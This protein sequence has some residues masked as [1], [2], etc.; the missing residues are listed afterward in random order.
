MLAART[1]KGPAWSASRATD[2]TAKHASELRD[3]FIPKFI[4]EENG[5]QRR[6]LLQDEIEST[7]VYPV[8]HMIRAVRYSQISLIFS[9]EFFI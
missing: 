4:M 1:L 6:P 3:D 2:A 9:I 8:I 7:D 5:Y